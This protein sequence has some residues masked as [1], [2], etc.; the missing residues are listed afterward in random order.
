LT[1]SALLASIASLGR[2]VSPLT[3][4]AADV[5]LEEVP[6]Y[7]RPGQT[8]Q[9][10]LALGA[11]HT[12]QS[13][14]ELEVSM[15]AL[16]AATRCEVTLG[17]DGAILP[18]LEATSTTCPATRTL[19]IATTIPH[20]IPVCLFIALQ[21]CCFGHPVL[22][23]PLEITLQCGIHAP[24]VLRGYAASSPCIAPTGLLYLPQFSNLAVF[25]ANGSALPSI[26]ASESRHDTCFR[27]RLHSGAFSPIA[28]GGQRW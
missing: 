13:Y 9:L 21:M 15:R 16:A 27:Q 7:V 2:I 3:I 19:R 24:L 28:S 11:R 22:K 18:V 17:V 6:C 12:R 10:C 1:R 25:D 5:S 8:L 20:D 23:H 4:L 14:E 26:K